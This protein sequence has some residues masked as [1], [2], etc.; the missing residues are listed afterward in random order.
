M[1]KGATS[2]GILFAVFLNAGSALAVEDTGLAQQAVPPAPVTRP[3]F[4]EPPRIIEIP[5]EV[6]SCPSV[7]ATPINL[8]PP[9]YDMKQGD[10]AL[11]GKTE[12]IEAYLRALEDTAAFCQARQES[13]WD[14]LEAAK[15]RLDREINAL[16]STQPTESTRRPGLPEPQDVVKDEP[17][18]REGWRYTNWLHS[19]RENTLT[20]CRMVDELP[21]T[22]AH[23]C[24]TI[25]QNV[26]NNGGGATDIQKMVFRQWLRR[27][28]NATRS[29]DYDAATQYYNETLQT[30][31]WNNFRRHF[32]EE[33]I[34]CGDR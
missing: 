29:Y 16:P 28:L 27:D 1:I 33:R 7:T 32:S 18:R 13:S 10:C 21:K 12:E 9:V 30:D 3:V 15:A 31:G 17:D 24:A 14:E 5:G 6:L 11:V 2:A 26:E 8:P 20:Y 25:S 19:I 22:L 34:S 23:T 4:I